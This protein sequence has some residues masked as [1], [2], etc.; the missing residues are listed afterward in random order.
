MYE[1]STFSWTFLTEF[2][3]IFFVRYHVMR[4]RSKI[5]KMITLISQIGITMLSSIFLCGGIGYLI[6][7]RFG[8]HTFI[9]ALLLGIAGGYRAVY[10]LV[11]QFTEK[12]KQDEDSPV[13]MSREDLETWKA[14]ADYWKQSSTEVDDELQGEDVP[15]GM[16]D[17]LDDDR[18]DR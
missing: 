16:R 6:D 11:K 13:S 10:V 1:N 9:F 7:N 12:D 3:I 14:G 5:V 2:S 17:D 4:D 15:P 8:T 18:M